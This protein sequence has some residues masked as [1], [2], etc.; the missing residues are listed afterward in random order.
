MRSA[1]AQDAEARL[2]GR[3][4]P[5][6]A[7]TLCSASVDARW[8]AIREILAAKDD[9]V[10]LAQALLHM[11]DAQ[12]AAKAIL[13][14]FGDHAVGPLERR[15]ASVDEEE[16]W[17]VLWG[18]A[19]TRC[20]AAAG[21]IEKYIDQAESIDAGPAAGLLPGMGDTGARAIVRLL[22]AERP[23]TRLAALEAVTEPG[24]EWKRF[25]DL[26]LL[27]ELCSSDSGDMRRAAAMATALLG[28]GAEAAL[29]SL[30]TLLWDREWQVRIAAAD[31]I[32]AIG[33]AARPA[34]EDLRAAAERDGAESQEW[35]G[36]TE[37]RRTA[38]RAIGS[39]GFR[40]PAVD[41]WLRTGTTDADP[42]TRV[43]AA[44]ALLLTDAS[45]PT[46]REV[47]LRELRADWTGG[48]SPW[49]RNETA[50]VPVLGV[51][52]E[53]GPSAAWALPAILDRMRGQHKGVD[54]RGECARTLG[55]LG[56]ADETT[57]GA[58]RSLLSDQAC[59]IG[60]A[61]A[62]C[63]LGQEPESVAELVGRQLEG[64][65]HLGREAFALLDAMGGDA[66][67]AL[68]CVSSALPEPTGFES[69]VSLLT[70][71]GPA[72]AVCAGELVPQLANPLTWQADL[73]REAL[74]AIGKAA[75]PAL[76]QGLEH[77]DSGVRRSVVLLLGRLRK[78]SPEAVGLLTAA[79]RDEDSETARLAREILESR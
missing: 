37:Y 65:G 76:G 53:L 1:W 61:F 31:A 35:G 25:L 20:E 28:V 63:K 64:G 48:E 69:A 50:T 56:S 27:L 58:L 43:M 40:S 52:A 71:F 78:E 79:T 68:P 18:L 47:L 39:I 60:A 32:A 15:L 51:F 22:H 45:D 70:R 46:A 74:E 36:A 62:L 10:L 34:G 72:S 24:V 4:A 73:V 7:E 13:R 75:L 6:W 23:E 33:A 42:T 12:C 66:A 16:S 26:R 38:I 29:N 55:C 3:T 49:F 21:V 2:S 59:V 57:I 5:E 19:S 54:I 67:G 9:G 44:R 41:A 11:T 17:F 30:R 77:S 14:E 8:R